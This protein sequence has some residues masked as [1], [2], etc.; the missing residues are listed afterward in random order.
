MGFKM[1]NGISGLGRSRTFPSFWNAQ[2]PARCQA[3]I[4]SARLVRNRQPTLC[5]AAGTTADHLAPLVQCGGN[6]R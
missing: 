2:R 1:G 3:A 4:R 5:A 6:A